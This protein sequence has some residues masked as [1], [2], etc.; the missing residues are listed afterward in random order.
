MRSRPTI[1]DVAA[2]AGV[3]KSLV[4]LALRGDDGVSPATRERIVA[5]ADELGY[6]SNALARAL[7]QTRTML[8]GV[9]VA[10]L[11]N[12]YHTEVVEAVERAAEKHGLSVL[13]AHGARKAGRMAERL[14]ALGD[15]NVDGLVV[16]SSWADPALLQ[17]AARR[18]PVAMVGRSLEPV[19]GIDSVNNDDEHGA[20]LAVGHLVAAGHERI[21]HLTSSRR[22][23]G[24]ARRAGY[25]AAMVSHGLA[26]HVR[27]IERDREEPAGPGLDAALADGCSAVFARND[28]EAFDVLDHAWD[29]GIDVPAGLAVVGYDDSALALRARPRLTSVHQPRAE[30][31]ALAVELLRERWSGRTTDRHEVL[32]PRLVVRASA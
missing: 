15:L 9:V 7:R 21:A 13:L 31:G 30:M 8:L 11:D 12:P 27:V 23:A 28:V 2:R 1:L 29:R 25:E 14:D 3:S 4:S 20:A 6:R 24:L 32:T 22:P 26:G 16:V 5:A 10:S 17:A 19:A 18:A